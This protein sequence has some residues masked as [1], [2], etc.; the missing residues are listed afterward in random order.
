MV[1]R[2]R[3]KE[4]IAGVLGWN[5]D[6]APNWPAQ[7]RDEHNAVIAAARAVAE[8]PQIWWC[9]THNAEGVGYPYDLC[10]MLRVF[11]VPAEEAVEPGVQGDIR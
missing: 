3:L 4:A 1:D 9:E 7:V 2:T 8:A 5:I 11:L 10:R 6:E